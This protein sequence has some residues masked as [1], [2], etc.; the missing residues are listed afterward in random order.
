[1][2]CREE[3]K[4]FFRSRSVTET[5]SP[6]HLLSAG[7]TAAPSYPPAVSA[8]PEPFAESHHQRPISLDQLEKGMVPVLHAVEIEEIE[9]DG[10][11]NKV[12]PVLITYYSIR[13]QGFGSVPYWYNANSDP[14]PIFFLTADPVVLF[15]LALILF[16]WGP[17]ENDI[18]FHEKKCQKGY[19]TNI[20]TSS[21]KFQ[22]NLYTEIRIRIFNADPEPGTQMNADPCGSGSETLTVKFLFEKKRFGAFSNIQGCGSAMI[23]CASGFVMIN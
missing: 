21:S 9:A 20:Y 15:S 6:S 14:D 4:L 10:G 16:S 5:A 8:V 22:W 11:P 2:S 3:E 18:F 7:G 17:I 23:L 1:M 13:V 19:F 12:L